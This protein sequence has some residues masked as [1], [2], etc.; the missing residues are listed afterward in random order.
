MS[1]NRSYGTW[2]ILLL[3]VDQS[4]NYAVAADDVN[5]NG[6]D[7]LQAIRDSCGRLCRNESFMTVDGR[8][9][10]NTSRHG[11]LGRDGLTLMA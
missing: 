5:V 8:H 9:F 6:E 1:S 7:W 2:G 11:P 4:G 3:R 10:N